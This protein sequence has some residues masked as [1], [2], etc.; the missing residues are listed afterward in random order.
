[1]LRPA[2]LDSTLIGPPLSMFSDPSVQ[3]VGAGLALAD[4]PPRSGYS[5]PRNHAIIGTAECRPGWLA[6]DSM[7]VGR[8]G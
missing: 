2:H 8:D 5:T 7:V 6:I 4:G 1:M 3:I